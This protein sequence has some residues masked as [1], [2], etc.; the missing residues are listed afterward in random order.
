MIKI[1][2]Q[3]HLASKENGIRFELSFTPSTGGGGS[4]GGRV[5]SIIS[6]SRLVLRQG[7]ES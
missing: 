4:K 5:C 7:F 6:V 1:Y 3:D 2:A